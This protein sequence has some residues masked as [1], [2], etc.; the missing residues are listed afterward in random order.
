MKKSKK[1]LIKVLGWLSVVLI[2][3]MNGLGIAATPKPR[4]AAT[5]PK[6]A[7][8]A[9]FTVASRIKDIGFLRDGIISDAPPGKVL[10]GRVGLNEMVF[11]APGQ[12]MRRVRFWL[13]AGETPVV[14]IDLAPAKNPLDPVWK[15]QEK[16][17]AADK[18]AK[19]ISIC[20]WYQ[21]KTNDASV[22]HRETFLDDVAV[23]EPTL[24]PMDEMRSL[25][26]IRDLNTY[27]SLV[28]RAYETK[29]LAVTQSIE[30]FYARRAGQNSVMQLAALHNFLRG[31]CPRVHA[32]WLDGEQT[33]A[34]N[35]QLTLYKALCVELSGQTDASQDLLQAALQ[36]NKTPPAYLFYHA[37]R[38]LLAKNATKSWELANT[39]VRLY[40]FDLPC[41]ELGAMA[42]RI[43]SKFFK[44]QRFNLEEGT[45]KTLLTLE[46]LLPKGKT[47]QAFFTV[48]QLLN[49]YPQSLEFYLFLAWTDS[50][51]QLAPHSEY[52]NRKLA[53][54][55]LMGGSTFDKII[56]ALEKGELP[57]LLIPAYR[58]KLKMDPADPNTWFRLIRAYAKAENCDQVL[59]TIKEGSAVLPKYSVPLLQMQASCYVQKEKLKDALE[60]YLKIVE[61]KPK[62]WTTYYNLAAV[63]ERLKMKKE[64]SEAYK[65][66]LQNAPPNDVKDN[67]QYRLLQIQ[68]EAV[69]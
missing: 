1:N 60:V 4:P 56:D 61:L 5:P 33:L 37:G 38:Q 22:C 24:F 13:K 11:S 64:A 20:N 25:L 12:G 7:P 58:S 67:V 43:D 26:G 68:N 32:I 35:P 10:P 40:P 63:Y 39:C 14:T 49:A 27:R 15:T 28:H 19:S 6:V 54:A 23:S 16:I 8:A 30:D 55:T 9:S 21:E 31:D 53:V 44:K 3:M 29:D 34:A 52:I 51:A 50:V 57:L 18:L 48:I 42:A 2:V 66:T 36:S 17:I 41:Q 47:D 69:P 45:F 59:E 62:A 65:Q 46:D